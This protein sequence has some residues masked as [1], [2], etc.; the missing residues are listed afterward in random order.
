MLMQKQTRFFF[1][2][3]VKVIVNLIRNIVLFKNCKDVA[4]GSLSKVRTKPRKKF[5][6]KAKAFFEV[7][8]FLVFLLTRTISLMFTKTYLSPSIF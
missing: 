3:L 1:E 6:T 2:G 4:I 8:G 5:L 7:L